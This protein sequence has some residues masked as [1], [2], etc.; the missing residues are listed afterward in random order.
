MLN[1]VKGLESGG[2]A[3]DVVGMEISIGGAMFT[4]I[5]NTRGA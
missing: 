4:V 5:P 3:T 1:W 2:D